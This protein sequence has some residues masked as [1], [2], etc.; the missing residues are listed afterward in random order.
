MFIAHA[1]AGFLLIKALVPKQKQRLML[2]CTGLFFAVA[3]DLDLF[4]FYFVSSRTVPHHQYPTHWPCLWVALF[5]AAL[6]LSSR[7]RKPALRPHLFV[8]FACVM[9]HLVLDSVAA[10]IFWLAPFSDFHI[11]FVTV[12][13]VENRW[14]VW[15]FI[16]HWTFA[17]EILTCLVA[18][19]VYLRSRRAPVRTEPAPNH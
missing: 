4:W 13:A 8:G 12:P 9:L 19:G 3:P 14:W 11:N 2:W 15:N 5:A 1:P 17:L 6:V 7:L 10:E 16:L 18:G